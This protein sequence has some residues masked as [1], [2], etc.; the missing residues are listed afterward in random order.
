MS[1]LNIALAIED[2]IK[3]LAQQG[4]ADQQAHYL[5]DRGVRGMQGRSQE[6]AVVEFLKQLHPE[7]AELDTEMSLIVDANGAGILT[8]YTNEAGFRGYSHKNLVRITGETTQLIKGFDHGKYP[9]LVNGVCVPA[10]CCGM[11][12]MSILAA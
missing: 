1:T 12:K 10:Y 6:C 8:R 9:E 11:P 4:T 3:T 2:G 5:A 7:L